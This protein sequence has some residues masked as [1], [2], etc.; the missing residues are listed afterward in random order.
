[1]AG[2]VFQCTEFRVGGTRVS[3]RAPELRRLAKMEMCQAEGSARSVV[4]PS[5]MFYLVL[6]RRVEVQPLWRKE[7]LG[8]L[9]S[10]LVIAKTEHCGPFHGPF[11]VQ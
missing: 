10:G 4:P 5:I 8:S 2:Q 7:N 9:R 11:M 6:A 3:D 1:M